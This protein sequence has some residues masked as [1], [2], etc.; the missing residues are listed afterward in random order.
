MIQ[1]YRSFNYTLV[2]LLPF[3]V[4]ET[5]IAKQRVLHPQCISVRCIVLARQKCIKALSKVALCGFDAMQSRPT[6]G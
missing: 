1:N 2:Q 3:F 5:D 4:V 6:D